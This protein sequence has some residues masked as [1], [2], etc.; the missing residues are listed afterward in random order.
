MGAVT[1]RHVAFAGDVDGRRWG[2]V[3]GNVHG[4]GWVDWF[5]G[6]PGTPAD[7]LV[8]AVGNNGQQPG[9]AAAIGEQ[10]DD[11]SSTVVVV[12]RPGD[13]A[14]RT[15]VEGSPGRGPM[16]GDPVEVPLADGVASLELPA[17]AGLTEVRV[18]RD[19]RTVASQLAGFSTA[20]HVAADLDTTAALA[21]AQP[22]R[23]VGG[24]ASGLAVDAALRAVL[25]PT[26]LGVDR[27][28]PV[29][30]WKGPIAMSGGVP[31]QGVV[32]ALTM[33]SGQVVTTTAW[34]VPDGSSLALSARGQGPCGTSVHPAGTSLDDLVVVA[35][36]A[37]GDG[38]VQ[39]RLIVTAPPAV[40]QVQ[41]EDGA[42][43]GAAQPLA[44]SGAVDDPGA[45]DSVTV[46][47][48]GLGPVSVPV[49]SSNGP[50]SLAGD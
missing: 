48:P 8:E 17:S 49:V 6:A 5:V 50:F 1:D 19:G 16:A 14:F 21:G 25:D 36:C 37:V 15:P 4:T 29:V 42:G 28:R 27:V 43:L 41:L 7:A 44:G 34:G 30:L 26:G 3:V 35:E 46:A 9:E 33:P 38:I 20:G 11:A 10:A 47:G 22:L 31:V 39:R 32:L 24:P 2:L 23:G 40:T 12:A 18:E 45:I 13:R